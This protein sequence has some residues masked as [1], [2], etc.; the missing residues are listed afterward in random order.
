MLYVVIIIYKGIMGVFC[1]CAWRFG[2]DTHLDCIVRRYGDW[3]TNE[4]A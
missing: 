2:Y 3:I 1:P 4:I